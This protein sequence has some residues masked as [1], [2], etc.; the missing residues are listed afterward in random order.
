M[1]KLS[2]FII[3]LVAIALAFPLSNMM[4][5]ANVDPTVAA[6][7]SDP[8]LQQLASTYQQK[9]FDC[10]SANA[11][12]P[13]YSSLPVAKAIIEKDRAEA[14]ARFDMVEEMFGSDGS[15]SEPAL[16]EI[17][18][19]VQDGSMPP[20]NYRLLHW[21]AA[22]SDQEKKDTLTWVHSTRARAYGAGNPD[23]AMFVEPVLPLKAVEGL[24]AEKVALGKK[25]F[26]DTRLSKDNS[27]SCASCHDLAKGGTDQAPV[28]TGVGG[29][30]G[31]INSPTVYNAVYAVAQFWD[32]RAKGLKEQAAGPVNNPIEMGSNWDE[33]LGKLKGDKEYE[34]A[35]KSL[36]PDG[37]TGDNITDS[38]A[39]FEKTLV[40]VNS[41]F[42]QYLRGKQD[43]LTGEEK[44]G[45]ALFKS[46]GC[47][48]CHVGQAVGGKSYEKMGLE[49]DYFSARGNVKEADNGR[50]N[51]T[52]R[53]NDRHK[54]KVPTLRNVAVTF[55]YFHDASATDLHQAIKTMAQ[56]QTDRTIDDNQ[57]HLIMLYLQTL[58]GEYEGQ[59]LR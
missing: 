20:S 28:S 34:A 46:Y 51:V 36:Y 35:F 15:V 40:T 32:G 29:Q 26:H 19:V 12:L 52:K 6:R 23:D 3:V 50:Y 27:L 59:V 25:L 43:A 13:F 37:I 41:R 7:A 10:H 47:S 39:E 17:Q 54:F 1:K 44:Q 33:V 2:F 9:C 48:N 18:H 31:P 38:I 45:Y 21:N 5:S 56:Y 57:T 14:L 58:T 16:A 49:Q 55:P 24:N 8:H 53:E 42:D 22:L 30:K 11:Q 4:R